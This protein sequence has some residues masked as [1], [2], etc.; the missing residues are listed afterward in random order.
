MPRGGDLGQV[1]RH[2][3]GVFGVFGHPNA[4]AL[5]YLAAALM[6]VMMLVRFILIVMGSRRR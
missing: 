3:G 1:R 6:S 4:A 2:F 5:T